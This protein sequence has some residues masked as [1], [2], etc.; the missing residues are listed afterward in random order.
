MYYMQG[1][2]QKSRERGA[3]VQFDIA[4]VSLKGGAGTSSL[5]MTRVS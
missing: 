2:S 5:C 4:R 3:A 1:H